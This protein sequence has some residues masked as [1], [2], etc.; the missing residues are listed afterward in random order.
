MNL[1]LFGHRQFA[2]G[3]IVSFIY[4]TALFGSTY[5]LPVYL[6]M[7]LGMSAAYV[8]NLMMPAG[9]VLAITIPIVGRRAGKLPTPLM[10]SIGLRR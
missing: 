7:G 9:L 2:M 3:S 4:G 8:G 1:A 6:Q 10:V 5:L